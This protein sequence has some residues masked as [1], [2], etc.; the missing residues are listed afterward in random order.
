MRGLGKRVVAPVLLIVTAIAV[1]VLVVAYP[2][3]QRLEGRSRPV[4]VVPFGST[5]KIDGV[6]WR[7]RTYDVP[8]DKYEKPPAHSSTVSVVF[9]RSADGKPAALAPPH[10]TCR[11]AFIGD[12][13][14]SWKSTRSPNKLPSPYQTICSTPGPF[15]VSMFVPKDAHVTATDIDLLG[16]P[17]TEVSST[18]VRFMM[19]SP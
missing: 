18:V 1:Y 7:L 13:G 6:L 12:H 8:I 17:E 5:V 19:T 2:Q 11:A 15:V 4:I 14:R 10:T 16:G 3:W 9:D